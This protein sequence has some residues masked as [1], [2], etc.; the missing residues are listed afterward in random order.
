MAYP[1]DMVAPMRAEVAGLG[2]TELRTAESART[3]MALPAGTALYFVNSV[4]GC[5]AGSARPGL[6]ASLASPVRPDR[7]YTV[8]A[9]NDVEAV[10]EVRSRILGYP[11]SSPCFALFKDGELVSMIER[12]QIQGLSAS[13]VGAK[14]AGLYAEHCAS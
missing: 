14:L 6:A 11:P 2:V 8:F 7:L 10:A 1:E 13:E 9:G 3:A 4:C 5:A 12:H